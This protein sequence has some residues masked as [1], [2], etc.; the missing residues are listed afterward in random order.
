[1]CYAKNCADGKSRKTQHAVLDCLRFL[2][3]P[4]AQSYRKLMSTKLVSE[5]TAEEDAAVELPLPE[6]CRTRFAPEASVS[7]R[8]DFLGQPPVKNFR[9]AEKRPGLRSFA[10]E[11]SLAAVACEGGVEAPWV[12]AGH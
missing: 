7:G 4:V 11:G 1:M 10:S 12:V 8:D 6:R 5:N 9:A 2:D 3:H